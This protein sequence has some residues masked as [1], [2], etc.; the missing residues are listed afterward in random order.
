MA[1]FVDT[2]TAMPEADILLAIK[3]HPLWTLTPEGKL[4]RTFRA[5][6]F[7][8]AMDFVSAVGA[9][10]NKYHHHPDIRIVESKK[11]EVSS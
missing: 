6:N 10:A 4:C 3:E 11:V 1:D 8:S 5:K 7:K 2:P 9:V